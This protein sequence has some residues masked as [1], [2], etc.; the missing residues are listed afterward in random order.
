MNTTLVI[1]IIILALELL[2]IDTWL[3]KYNMAIAKPMFFS[4][5]LIAVFVLSLLGFSKAFH[6]YDYLIAVIAC[7]YEWIIFFRNTQNKQKQT[8]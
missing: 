3:I 1:I 7:I 5:A 4:L 2:P 8:N 6:W